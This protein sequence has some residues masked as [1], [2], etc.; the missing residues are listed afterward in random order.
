MRKIPE[1]RRSQRSVRPRR[2]KISGVDQIRRE[3]E[4]EERE[5]WIKRETEKERERIGGSPS[6]FVIVGVFRLFLGCH[7][8]MSDSQRLISKVFIYFLI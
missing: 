6:S 2:R 3:K 4:T 5:G 1:K 7:N 8:V